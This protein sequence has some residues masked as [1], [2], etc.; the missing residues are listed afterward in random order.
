MSSQLPLVPPFLFSSASSACPHPGPGALETVP[1]LRPLAPHH[2]CP[3]GLSWGQ[4][5]LLKPKS[6]HSFA[7]NTFYSGINSF[8]LPKCSFWD[9]KAGGVMALYLGA[10]LTIWKLCLPQHWD[11][12]MLGRL[13]KSKMHNCSEEFHFNFGKKNTPEMPRKKHGTM[14]TVAASE[15]KWGAGYWGWLK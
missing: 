3:G 7:W 4:G 14:L 8:E 12:F 15:A 10:Y 5:N 9:G 1:S 13:S 2:T 6:L 11:M